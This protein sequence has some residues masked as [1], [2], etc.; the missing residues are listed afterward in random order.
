MKIIVD[1]GGTRGRWV[2]VD[3]KVI[4]TVETAGFNPYSCK[5]SSLEKII[6]SIN[7][8]FRKYKI[9][10]ILIDL[11]SLAS[12]AGVSFV[13]EDITGIAPNKKKLLLAKK[14]T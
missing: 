13:M 11:R 5:N 7:S 2:L 12:K 6:I 8:S 10:E 4:K 9:D 1:V 3:K 14:Q